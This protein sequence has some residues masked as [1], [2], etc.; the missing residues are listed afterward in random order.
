METPIRVL[1]VLTAMDL[2]GTETLLMNFYRNINRENV[3]FDFA[4]SATQECAYD[5]EIEELGGYIFHYPRYKGTNHF[6][7]KKWWEEF[8]DEHTEYHVVHGHIGST[9][10]IYLSIANKK[11]RYTIAH[12]HS[13]NST[14]K[15][16][17]II[18]GLF[19]YPT[20]YIADYFFGCSLN[21]KQTF[22]FQITF[23]VM[24]LIVLFYMI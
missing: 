23:Q 11:G 24:K 6:A 13:T 4:V 21:L 5:R 1:H 10:A 22:L 16:N 2:A 9:A 14:V 3:Q 19:S 17:S 12:S 18:Y 20:R 15:I 7:Y 8:L